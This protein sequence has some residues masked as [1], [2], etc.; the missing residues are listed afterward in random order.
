[1]T[2]AEAV[3]NT[4]AYTALKRD[5]EKATISHAYMLIS[6]D[7]EARKEFFTLAA[8]L[9][10]CPKGGCGICTVCRQ[11]DSGTQPDVKYYGE[12]LNVRETEALTEDTELLPVAADRKLY[13]IDNAE[14]LR[15]DA[16]NKL[17][18]TYEEPSGYVTVILA[19]SQENAILSTLRSRA[20]KLV[21]EP[22]SS[23]TIKMLLIESGHDENRADTI[24]AFSLGSFERAELLA[25]NEAYQ[26]L[27]SKAVE[28]LTGLK[29]SKSV[30]N[31]LDSP[32]FKKE[33]IQLSLDI[34]EIILSDVLA[35]SAGAATERKIIN[36][37]YDIKKLAERLTPAAIAR[38]NQS[39]GY[40][41]EK[42]FFNIN[43]TTVAERLLFEIVEAE[44]KWQ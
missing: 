10:L 31:F 43:A 7:S 12:R 13:F 16:Q 2:L 11:L 29:G 44:Y 5:V 36:R 3:R 26:E 32:L 19:C 22:F 20:K 35:V 24:A 25:G 38:I 4:S 15:H 14:K 34:L 42:L 41:R 37:A 1:M 6:P 33:N 18:K 8:K 39:I 40:A 17:L 28:L 23:E 27:F 21:I 30:V 9:I